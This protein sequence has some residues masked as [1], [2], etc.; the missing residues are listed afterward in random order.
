[1]KFTNFHAI[2]VP[3]TQELHQVLTYLDLIE[4]G[5]WKGEANPL[6]VG[7]CFFVF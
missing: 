2:K 7:F 5:T 3:E 4:T 1:L 6:S